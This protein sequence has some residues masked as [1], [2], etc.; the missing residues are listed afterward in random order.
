[1]AETLIKTSLVSS[2]RGNKNQQLQRA[3]MVPKTGVGS[4]PSLKLK[5]Q[6]LRSSFSS[7]FH[8]KKPLFRVTRSIPSKRINSQFSVSA[9]PKVGS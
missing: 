8:G 1:M 3:S 9:A 6:F 5:S 7:E 2:W 4:Y